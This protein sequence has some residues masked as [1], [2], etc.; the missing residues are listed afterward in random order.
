MPLRPLAPPPLSAAF[1]QISSNAAVVNLI[2]M[3]EY[4]KRA[5]YCEMREPLTSVRTRRRSDGVNGDKVVKEGIREMNS[6]M[7]LSMDV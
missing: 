5:V 2:S 3:P 4:P 6:G 1:R 7:K